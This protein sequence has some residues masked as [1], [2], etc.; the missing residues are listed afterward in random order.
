MKISSLQSFGMRIEFFVQY[1]HE[2]AFEFE[3]LDHHPCPTSMI[4]AY[5][6]GDIQE[7]ISDGIQTKFEIIEKLINDDAINARVCRR[8]NFADNLTHDEIATYIIFAEQLLINLGISNYAGRYTQQMQ[9]KKTVLKDRLGAFCVPIN[10]CTPTDLVAYERTLLPYTIDS[11]NFLAR[12]VLDTVHSPTFT[13]RGKRM[14]SHLIAEATNLGKRVYL[15]Y[16]YV[17]AMERIHCFLVVAGGHESPTYTPLISINYD[18]IA[19]DLP[20]A[21]RC[22]LV[23]NIMCELCSVYD[24]AWYTMVNDCRKNARVSNVDRN[25]FPKTKEGLQDFL[26]NHSGS[27][28]HMILH[29][30]SNKYPRIDNEGRQNITVLNIFAGVQQKYFFCTHIILGSFLN[31]YYISIDALYKMCFGN[32]N[33]SARSWSTFC[34]SLIAR[35]VESIWLSIKSAR[36]GRLA[37]LDGVL[38][39][40]PTSTFHGESEQEDLLIMF[41]LDHLKYCFG[42]QF[43]NWHCVGETVTHTPIV[44]Y[45][46]SACVRKEIGSICVCSLSLNRIPAIQNGAECVREVLDQL[47]Y[48]NTKDNFWICLNK[49]YSPFNFGVMVLCRVFCDFIVSKYNEGDSTAASPQA[50]YQFM[51]DIPIGDGNSLDMIFGNKSATET[52]LKNHLTSKMQGIKYLDVRHD[53]SYLEAKTTC[54][55]YRAF[56]IGR[57]DLSPHNLLTLFTN[58]TENLRRPAQ[59]ETFEIFDTDTIHLVALGQRLSGVGHANLGSAIVHAC[60]H[61]VLTQQ[62]FSK[63]LSF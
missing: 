58:S 13:L 59:P 28:P 33:E 32:G 2:Y 44:W 18:R 11:S 41:S 16:L 26:D 4:E 57:R 40:H 9:R 25:T 56:C 23:R 39:N 15:P 30:R 48:G 3:N 51:S 52:Y 14:E 49:T 42:R 35:S 8:S 36:E 20:Q 46:S 47:D 29:P 62:L 12:P 54:K 22:T 27:Y 61:G 53:K 1:K 7:F 19:C 38:E 10:L 43:T 50:L 45:T 55:F 21:D 5:S 31:L 6:T 63:I 24:Y 34:C 37:V 17:Q 60:L